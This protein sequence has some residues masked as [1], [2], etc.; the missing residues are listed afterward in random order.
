MTKQLLFL[1]LLFS[2][3][4]N[5]QTAKGIDS[6]FLVKNYLLDVQTIINAK[7]LENQK[8][9]KLDSFIRSAT[10]QKAIFGRNINSIVQNN[11]EAEEMKTSLNFILQ[12]M[13]V[14]KTD[15]K[16]NQPKQA[17]TEILYLNKNIPILINKI[18]FYT[19]RFQN[20]REEKTN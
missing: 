14:Y 15:I 17:R 10:K 12:S 20:F 13:V 2:I 1:L 8:I 7:Q 6:L 18:Y 16:N 5:A 4:V 9:E 11:Q 19:K 3:K